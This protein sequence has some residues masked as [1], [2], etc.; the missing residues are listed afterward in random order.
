MQTEI[1]NSQLRTTF[2]KNTK[3]IAVSSQR[4]SLNR[5]LSQMW[6]LFAAPMLLFITLPLFALFSQTSAAEVV[7]YLNNPQVVQAIGLSLV[8]SIISTLAT[9]LFG[10]P[11]AY[12]LA[13]PNSVSPPV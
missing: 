1:Q 10:T 7:Q 2:V 12:R 4:G 9:V 3:Q 8:S 6:K 13:Q 11:V 5:Q